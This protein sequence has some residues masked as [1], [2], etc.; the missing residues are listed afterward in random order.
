MHELRYPEMSNALEAPLYMYPVYILHCAINRCPLATRI[1][2]SEQMCVQIY[3][4]CTCSYDD[5]MM[6]SLMQGGDRLGGHWVG[7]QCRVSQPHREGRSSH[8]SV[9]WYMICLFLILCPWLLIIKAA[10]AL[11]VP[12]FVIIIIDE[13]HVLCVYLSSSLS[14]NPPSFSSTKLLSDGTFL[15]LLIFS[16]R[17]WEC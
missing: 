7:G 2:C 3:C 14:P 6:T 10:L 15:R 4:T 9:L 16:S 11:I 5:V 8:Q 17:N 1:C 13:L 12:V